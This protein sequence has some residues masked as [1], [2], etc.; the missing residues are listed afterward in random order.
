MSAIQSWLAKVCAPYPS[1]GDLAR[2]VWH[3]VDR[4]RTLQV[5]TE[6]YTY[7]TGQTHLLLQTYGTLPI[8]YR[9][10]TY[11][12]PLCIWFPLEYP[13]RAPM[14]Y[15]QPTRGMGIRVGGGVAGDGRVTG[16]VV[17]D[18]ERKWEGHTL[19]SLIENIQ[20]MFS[21]QPPVYALPSEQSRAQPP[22]ARPAPP[23]RPPTDQLPMYQPRPAPRPLDIPPSP[24][25]STGPLPP[26]VPPSPLRQHARQGSLPPAVASPLRTNS[27][28]SAAQIPDPRNGAPP[29]APRPQGPYAQGYMPVSQAAPPPHPTPLVAASPVHQPQP[30]R[31]APKPPVRD[32]FD[33]DDP[34]PTLIPSPSPGP[35]VSG[36]APT[37]PLPPSTL[38]LHSLLSAQLGA[39]MPML[40]AHLSSQ[41]AQL[42]SVHADLESGEP[43]IRDEMARLE[44]VRGVC[45]GVV[46]K[47]DEVVRNGQKRCEELEAKGEVSVDEV[48]CSISIV[49]NQLI[50]LVAEDNAI[51]DTIYHLARALDAER[52]DLD[53][54]LKQIRV[55][56]REQY[57]K[58]ALIE[59]ITM[60]LRG[61]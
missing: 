8:T 4:W 18:W 25:S 42:E 44:A 47:V 43:A 6:V 3:V 58:R 26:P 37:R 57:Q 39:R 46:S 16:G 27:I 56:A 19:A 31:A 40:L 52:I 49:H 32:L 29:L 35:R 12:I 53:R 9:H 48:V 41:T 50:D 61:R 54:F 2:E 1:A 22:P 38:H 13:R 24:T 30:P 14:V 36:P 55:L 7:D 59:K 20:Q 23:S 15:V 60:E 45:E 21:A 5:R 10:A 11:H 34:D 17:A 51:E 28:S 33:V